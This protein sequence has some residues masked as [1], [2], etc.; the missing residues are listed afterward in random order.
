MLSILDLLDIDRARGRH[1]CL[2]CDSSKSLSVAP[3]KGDSGVAHCFACGG[4][5]TG[6]QM[7]AALG[8]GSIAEGMEAFGLSDDDW[9]ADTRKTAE[10]AKEVQKRRKEQ[11]REKRLR[12]FWKTY[13]D[14]MAELDAFWATCTE[15]EQQR[16]DSAL[17]HCTRPSLSAARTLRQVVTRR[18]E[19]Q[20]RP[21]WTWSEVR[22]CAPYMLPSELWIIE[23]YDWLHDRGQVSAERVAAKMATLLRIADERAHTEEDAVRRFECGSLADV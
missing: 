21:A 20:Q 10:R 1:P 6:V 4:S 11:R 22:Q 3:D 16:H 8:M 5:W 19:D 17:Q 14:Y 15:Q 9:S 18:V 12:W 13:V 2:V 7:Y 23:R